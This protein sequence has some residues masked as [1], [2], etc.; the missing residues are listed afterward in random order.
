MIDSSFGRGWRCEQ[1]YRESTG[2]CAPVNVPANAYALNSPSG[3]GWRC[4]RGF[5]QTAGACAEVV[6]P[7]NAIL[8]SSGERW[9]CLRGFARSV[10]SCVSE[11]VVDAPAESADDVLLHEMHERQ[12][13]GRTDQRDDE[14]EAR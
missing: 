12:H 13:E 11:C 2:L 14:A 6:V 1:G 8:D 9:T 10:N 7:L 4:E 3:S 5:L